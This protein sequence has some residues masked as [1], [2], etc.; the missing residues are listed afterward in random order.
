MNLPRLF[1]GAEINV[2][3]HATENESAIAGAL[4][5]NFSLPSHK[6]IMDKVEG[7]WGNVIYFLNITVGSHEANIVADKIFK[8]LKSIDKYELKD[9]LNHQ[10]DESGNIY[11]RL[12]KQKIINNK[13]SF[14]ERDSIRI[15]FKPLRKF[16]P[17]DYSKYY[18]VLFALSE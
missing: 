6:I 14:T 5:R 7:H 10:I 2:V 13:I 4:E 1:S 8:S 9:R 17:S 12:D 15:K 3:I 11:L 18:E 16:K